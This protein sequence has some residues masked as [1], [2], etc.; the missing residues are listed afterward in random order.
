MSTF[1]RVSWPVGAVRYYARTDEAE[2]LGVSETRG[3]RRIDRIL[4]PG[5]AEGLETLELDELR[6]RRDECLAEREYLSLLRR[7]LQGRLDI[8]RA[9][10]IRRE[11][12]GD[13]AP[14]LDQL[15]DIL[16]SDSSSASRG[17]LVRV[18]VPEE[19]MTLARRR[20][21]R[22]IADATISDAPSLPDDELQSFT[23]VLEREEREVSDRRSQVIGIHDR[24]QEELKRRYKEDLS[25]ITTS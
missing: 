24:L 6:R 16:G 11:E 1:D 17:E 21:E 7:F 2:R 19:E 5:Y 25:Q 15:S 23:A 9:E 8:L 3:N 14:L 12:G 4:S 22:L 13:P 10:A 18:S 20:V